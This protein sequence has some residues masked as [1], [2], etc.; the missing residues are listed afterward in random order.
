MPCNMLLRQFAWRRR[1]CANH[2]LISRATPPTSHAEVTRDASYA[3]CN[4]FPEAV[5][6]HSQ[7]E[8]AR[9]ETRGL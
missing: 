6:S 3:Q 5:E 8:K 7:E 2:T 9:A 1:F 4:S